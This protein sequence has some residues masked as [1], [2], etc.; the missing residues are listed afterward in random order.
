VP[1]DGKPDDLSTLIRWDDLTRNADLIPAKHI[2]FVMDA[3]YGGLALLRAPSFGSMRFLG[4]MIQRYSRQVLTAGKANETVADGN[5]VRPGHSIFTAHMLNA[6]E[7]AAATENGVITANGVMAYVYDR[8]ARDQY[9]H[10]TPHYG[11]VDGDGD[12]VF[13]TSLLDT[14][15]GS[16]LSAATDGADKGEPGEPDILV[17]T[18]P[19]LSTLP[20]QEP[21]IAEKMK[22]LLPDPAKRIELDDFVSMHIRLFLDGADL[23]HF[24]AQ[25][26][27]ITNEQFTARVQA[28]ETLT[29]DLQQIAILLAKWGDASQLVL[30]E[31]IFKRLAEADKGSAGYTLWLQ[32]GWYPLTLL[33]Y[34]VGIT[35]LATQRYEPMQLAFQTLVDIDR[36][37]RDGRVP[38]VVPIIDNMTPLHDAFKMLPGHERDFVARS[39][40]MF[41]ELQPALED[42][43]LLGRSYETLF[44]DF[45]VLLGLAYS[46]LTGQEWGPVGRFG[47]KQRRGL[48]DSPFNRVADEAKAAGPSW[49]PLKAGLFGGSSERLAKAV[50]AYKDILPRLPMF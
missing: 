42:A 30:M 17:N 15:R 16:A 40:H 13:D 7:G 26:A 21:A 47:W 20:E 41:K 8:V 12:F 34:S 29:A 4:D 38:V 18:S 45:E 35:A 3:C 27:A 10:Q 11:F 24:P 25:G 23:R 39:E 2:F 5:G 6:L 48:Q 9:S 49:R 19:Q 33:A 31:H 50:N 28:Y 32:L 37:R 36:G 44:D 22:A 46:D 14:V 43:L 1:V